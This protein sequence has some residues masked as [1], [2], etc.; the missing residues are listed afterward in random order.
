MDA[1]QTYSSDVAFTPS[2]KDI[3]ARRGSR[4]AFAHREAVGGALP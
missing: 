1:Q 3:Q 4:K 2:V